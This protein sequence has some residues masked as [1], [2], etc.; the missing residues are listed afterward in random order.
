M[1]V[2]TVDLSWS[3]AT[4]ASV[5]IYRDGVVVATVPNSGAYTDDTG[6]R[7]G[8]V[9]YTYTVCEADTGTCSNEVTV[10]F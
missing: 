5:D 1:G 3:G 6:N 8:N 4:S 9:Q 2:H 10:G 7:G